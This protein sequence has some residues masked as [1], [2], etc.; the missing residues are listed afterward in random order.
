MGAGEIADALISNM[1]SNA[2]AAPGDIVVYNRNHNRM[3][4][5]REK[6]GVTVASDNA[7]VVARS[8]YVF[9]CVRPEQTPALL[10]EIRRCDMSG[11]V[12]VS[13]SA[14]VPLQVFESAFPEAAIVRSL[15]NMPSKIGLGVIA[16]AFNDR[17]DERQKDGV[18]ALFS[19]MGKCFRLREDLIDVVTPTTSVVHFLAM[20]QACVEGSALMGMDY[21][22]SR[23]LVMQTVRGALR[24]WEDR[25]EE[26]GQ[27]ID[28]SATP[29]GISVRMLHFLDR[30]G[31]RHA[32]KE[33]I[34]EGTLRT[35]AFGDA[36]RK[37]LDSGQ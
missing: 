8:E 1:V 25:P 10:D 33:C 26:L 6:Y 30:Y 20:F 36:I 13:V 22:T 29:G 19:A 17:C 37:R 27:C 3:H 5:L 23:E 7:E 31:F 12:L 14:G 11:R 35:R 24:I 4:S 32:V 2:V 28:E 9:S 34:E 15:P 16:L 21:A 18:M